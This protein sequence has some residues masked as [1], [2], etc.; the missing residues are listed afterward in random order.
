MVAC[1]RLQVL[2]NDDL[3]EPRGIALAPEHGWM[4]WSDWNEKRPK[5]ERAA[6]DGSERMLLASTNL[7]WPN[8][9]TLDL[10]RS[11]IY[12]C[13]AKTDKIEVRLETDWCAVCSC[14]L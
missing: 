14:L 10:K 9:I 12:W 2:I 4:F 8:G 13:D 7:G 6:M 1:S 3:L 5:I 11:K